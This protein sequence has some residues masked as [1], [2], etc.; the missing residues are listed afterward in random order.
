[1]ASTPDVVGRQSDTFLISVINYKPGISPT[2]D[3]IN[4]NTIILRWPTHLVE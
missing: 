1:M 2:F 4:Q 3:E